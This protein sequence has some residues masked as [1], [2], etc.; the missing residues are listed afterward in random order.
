MEP[1]KKRWMSVRR[2]GFGLSVR[3][4]VVEL[5]I[6]HFGIA[7]STPVNACPLAASTN[8]HGG[9]LLCPLWTNDH[10]S[11]TL[12]TPNVSSSRKLVVK[13]RWLDSWWMRRCAGD[14]RCGWRRA[15]V[16]VVQEDEPRPTAYPPTY[17]RTYGHRRWVIGVIS[18]M[19]VN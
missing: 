17:P 19:N 9:F 3:W 7:S 12:Q 16:Y 1:P 15:M 10:I 11:L 5:G 8:L 2:L 14:E 18:V 4:R 13:S 6:P